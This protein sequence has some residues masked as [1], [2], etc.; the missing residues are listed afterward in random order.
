M[1]TEHP[2]GEHLFIEKGSRGYALYSKAPEFSHTTHDAR[3]YFSTMRELLQFVEKYL[4]K[5]K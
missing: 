3:W 2:T 4:G 1:A 5:K